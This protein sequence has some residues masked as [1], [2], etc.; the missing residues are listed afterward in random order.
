[1]RAHWVCSRERRIALYKRSSIIN[2]NKTHQGVQSMTGPF[3]DDRNRRN[4]GLEPCCFVP[5]PSRNK[6]RN[7]ILP[8]HRPM[9][10]PSNR[11]WASSTE[12]RDTWRNS[13]KKRVS[14]GLSLGSLN[15]AK[16]SVGV[17]A[18]NLTKF[19][20]VGG[21]VQRLWGRGGGGFK[22]G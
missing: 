17:W 22:T 13:S 12:T 2:Q 5:P 15:M 14:S 16:F 19:G 8:G 9:K 20:W 7:G 18:L 6:N 10:E 1:M 21:R 3:S 4:G 11:C